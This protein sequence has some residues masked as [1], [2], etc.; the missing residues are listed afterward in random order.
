MR[1]IP[2]APMAEPKCNARRSAVKSY[3]QLHTYARAKVCRQRN[4]VLSVTGEGGIQAVGRCTSRPWPC[5]HL[6][7]RVTSEPVAHRCTGCEGR[8]RG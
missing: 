3:K 6:Q 4:R 2:F 8:A 7:V 1:S 5:A